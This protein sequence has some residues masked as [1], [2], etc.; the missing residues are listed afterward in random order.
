MDHELADCAR[1]SSLRWIGIEVVVAPVDPVGNRSSPQVR[2]RIRGVGNP[3]TRRGPSVDDGGGRRPGPRLFIRR[4]PGWG[5]GSTPEVRLSS[6]CPHV[7]HC[8]WMTWCVRVV[9]VVADGAPES[10]KVRE[11]VSGATRT[12][13]GCLAITSRQ[14]ERPAP[15]TMR[16]RRTAVCPQSCPHLCTVQGSPSRGRTDRPQVQGA[17]SRQVCGAAGAGSLRR[18]SSAGSGW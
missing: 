1:M 2:T 18:G 16:R 8:P 3:W 5:R 15:F 6:G 17:D 9:R 14:P 4:P 11:G 10:C 7:V 12:T 13:A